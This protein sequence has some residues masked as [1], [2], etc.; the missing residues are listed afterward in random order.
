MGRT[1]KMLFVENYDAKSL[2]RSSVSMIDKYNGRLNIVGMLLIR[3]SALIDNLLSLIRDVRNTLGR[4]KQRVYDNLNQV[5]EVINGNDIKGT[6]GTISAIE[7]ALKAGDKAIDEAE[8]TLEGVQKEI[9][10]N[11]E[12]VVKTQP[13]SDCGE[14]C[15]EVPSETETTEGCN[16]CAYTISTEG[17]EWGDKTETCNVCTHG[18]CNV[19]TSCDEVSYIHPDPD[20]PGCSHTSTYVDACNETIRQDLEC[21]QTTCNH[22]SDQVMPPD[23]SFNCNHSSPCQESPMPENCTYT[24]TDG[25]GCAYSGDDCS[26][27]TVCGQ[28]ES[29]NQYA[30]NQYDCGEPCGETCHMTSCE[31]DCSEEDSE[32]CGDCGDCGNCGEGDGCGDWSEFCGE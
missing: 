31:E 4:C 7:D 2:D 14:T 32:G 10:C 13:E 30:C 20:N 9:E 26:Y 29:C 6:E 18:E 8:S 24:C 27:G 23:C 21:S 16:Y 1:Y 11:E 5:K 25:A 22:S 17:S 3:L 19:N 15:N 28:E 12:P